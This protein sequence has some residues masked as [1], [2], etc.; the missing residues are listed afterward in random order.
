MNSK[1]LVYGIIGF[2]LGGLV[3]ST[4][5]VTLDK[6]DAMTMQEMTAS[7]N[8]KKG[9]DYDKAFVEAMIEHH[10]G[11]IDMAEMSAANAKHPE[12]KQLSK[13]ILSAQKSE[14]EQMQQWQKDWG[15]PHSSSEQMS[16]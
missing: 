15:Y 14:I 2:L 9:D 5:A 11:A 1:A 10:Q 12:I 8:D 4:A 6:D 13:D 7:L 16:H 3:V